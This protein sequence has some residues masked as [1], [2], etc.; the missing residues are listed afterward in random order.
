MDYNEKVA[1]FLSQKVF[2]V[3]GVSRSGKKV[4][5]FIYKKFKDEGFTVY[6]IN[7]AAEGNGRDRYYADIR[8]APE[9]IDAVLIATNPESSMAAAKQCV[10]NGVRWI[11]FH[12]SMG[13]GSYSPA[14]AEFAESRGV[15]VIHSGCPMMFIKHADGAHRM[16]AFFMR[17]FGK[18]KE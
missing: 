1:Q 4:G 18:L 17:L 9:K 11:W 16:M 2:A 3:A 13:Q 7:P 8:S 6:A 5:N 10:E 12:H 14:A 15:N